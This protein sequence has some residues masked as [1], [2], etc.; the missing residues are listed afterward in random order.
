MKT[1]RPVERVRLN[2][3]LGVWCL[4]V[5]GGIVVRACAGGCGVVSVE[6]VV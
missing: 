2:A 3:W 4:G 6:G 1:Q 5:A